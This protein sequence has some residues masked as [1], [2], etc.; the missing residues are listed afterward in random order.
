MFMG[1][2]KCNLA[3]FQSPQNYMMFVG[4]LKFQKGL[5]RC[6]SNCKILLKKKFLTFKYR[7]N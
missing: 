6:K 4:V 7:Q 2:V 5:N 1:F 3:G